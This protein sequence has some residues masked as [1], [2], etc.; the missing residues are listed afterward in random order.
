METL[1]DTIINIIYEYIDSISMKK[2]LEARINELSDI[3]IISIICGAEKSL[4]KKLSSLSDLYEIIIKDSSREIGRY[5][6]TIKELNQALDE[7]KNKDGEIFILETID[8]DE[9][10]KEHFTTNFEPFMTF[11]KLIDKIKCTHS[12]NAGSDD[13]KYYWYI[14]KKYGLDDRGEFKEI[15][16]WIISES[17]EI[18]YSESLFTLSTLNLPIPFKAGD[19]VIIDC[20]PF[21]PVKKGIITDVGDNKDCCSVQC[22][23][24]DKDANIQIGP[25]KHNIIFDSGIYPVPFSALYRLEKV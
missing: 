7:C 9:R 15:F 20:M 2:Y 5:N 4:E 3:E 21:V 6:E 17:G 24:V 11:D 10:I 1:N 23:W 12:L 22:A 13:T 8:Y 16:S 25:L 19:E 14:A 18:W